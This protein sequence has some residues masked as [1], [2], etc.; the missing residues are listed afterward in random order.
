MKFLHV[1]FHTQDPRITEWETVFNVAPDW[2]RY[3]SHCWILYTSSSPQ[4]WFNVI[5][6]HLKEGEYFFV[7]EVNLANRTGW[8]PQTVWD[9]IGKPR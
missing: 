1:G 4:H 5:K 6:P 2:V 7:C 8:M 9:W 3:S